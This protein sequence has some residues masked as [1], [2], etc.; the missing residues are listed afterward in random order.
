[1]T[2]EEKEAA[3]GI[4]QA[5]NIAEEMG[6]ALAH[7]TDSAKVAIYASAI[8]FAGMCVSSNVSM[9]SAVSLLM[10]IYKEMDEKNQDGFIQ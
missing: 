7:H 4:R 1:M 9:H 10:S 8:T 6:I 2:P 5:K 3:E